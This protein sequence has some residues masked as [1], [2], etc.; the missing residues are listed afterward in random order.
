MV[1]PLIT[2]E[3]FEKRLGRNLEK[4][5]IERAEIAIEDATVLINFYICR[6]IDEKTLPLLKIFCAQVAIR[7]FLYAYNS[8]T[9]E[10]NENI[11]SE[12]IG[13]YSYRLANTQI[14]SKQKLL[15]DEIGELKRILGSLNAYS[16]RTPSAYSN[17]D[18]PKPLSSC[19]KNPQCDPNHEVKPE[20]IVSGELSEDVEIR[21]N[22]RLKL[23]R[24]KGLSQ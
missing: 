24:E 10:R 7:L 12:S 9:G 17:F 1:K 8:K 21:I 18:P 2:L 5:E 16:V 22:Q 19:P 11:I 23:S 3:Y 6:K 15:P 20:N 14:L 4:S 13:D